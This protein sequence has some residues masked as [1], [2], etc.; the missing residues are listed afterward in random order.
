MRKL[1][2]RGVAAI[3]V[4]VILLVSTG[5]AISTPVIVDLVDVDP[6]SPFYGLERL[7]E[8][9]R[10][11]GDE[12][13]M[14][15]RWS[16]YAK[17][18]DRAKGLEYK[19]ILQEFVEKIHKVVPGDSA[20][21]QEIVQWMQMQMPEIGQVKLKLMKELCEELK[22]ELPELSGEL[23]N[24]LEDLEN[25]EIGVPEVTTV[26]DNVQAHLQLK[27][28][29]LWQIAQQYQPQVSEK[30]WDYFDIENVLVDVN[31]TAN[32][33]IDMTVIQPI[34]I[35]TPKFGEKLEEFNTSL[36]EIQAMLEGT[37]ENAF[38]RHAA[39]RLV[40]VAI[41]LR[42][43]AVNAHET[44]K[45]R[46]ALALIHAAQ[47]HLR[48]AETILNHASEWEPEFSEDWTR[49]QVAWENMRQEWM[50][51]GTWQ[52]I[53]ENYP[54]HA[55]NIEHEWEEHMREMDVGGGY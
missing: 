42:D 4:V 30:I 24:E 29:R 36:S 40:E 34:P 20:A 28:Q 21:K 54:Q 43:E 47:I 26:S 18:V 55:E 33:E 41:K 16:E 32:V 3:P 49:W 14:K 1:D 12:D 38:G 22:D 45:I 13:Q 5:A 9:V 15:E 11:V 23:E 44:G 50:E 6:D 37:P 8:R 31:V 48:N 2:Q 17:L 10:F 35:T 27:F 52:S 51:Q 25:I 46:K 7:G 39:E 53:L 19:H